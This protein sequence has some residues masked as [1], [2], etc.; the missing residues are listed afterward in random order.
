MT[1]FPVQKDSRRGAA[2]N[3]RIFSRLVFIDRFCYPAEVQPLPEIAPGLGNSFASTHWSVI[4][5]AGKSES[6]P[7]TAQAALTQL[8]Q[9]YWAPLYN[10]VRS[11]GYSTHDAQD[12]TQSFFAFLIERKI[13]ARVDRQKGKFRSFLLASLKNFLANTYDHAHAFK[14]GGEHELLPL[15]EEQV[16]EAESLY[17]TQLDAGEDR[18]FERSWAETLVRER[19]SD[20]SRFITKPKA[21]K[22]FLRNCEFFSRAALIRCR[23]TPIW[24]SGWERRNRPCAVTSRGCGRVTGMRCAPRCGARWKPRKKSTESCANCCAC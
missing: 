12:L 7:E 3:R 6:D 20:N 4:V 19:V 11:R 5:A 23:L 10:F 15:D 8:C 2:G 9:T 21:K 22:L 14:R 24:R 1:A 17:Q 13:Y 16:A 18:I